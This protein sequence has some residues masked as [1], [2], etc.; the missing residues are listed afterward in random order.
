MWLVRPVRSVCHQL[1]LFL[2]AFLLCSSIVTARDNAHTAVRGLASTVFPSFDPAHGPPAGTPS[3]DVF[4][5]SQAYPSVYDSTASFPW[6]TIDFRLHPHSYMRAVLDYCLEGNLAVDFRLQAN[7]TRKW[8]HAP[9]LHDD[10]D[11]EK[12]GSGREFRHGLTRERRSRPG[13][14]HPLQT[15]ETQNWA[16]G[17]YN[18]RGGQALYK[19]WRVAAAYPDPT[20]VVFPENSVACKLLFSDADATSKVPFL[21]G[22]KEWIANIYAVPRPQAGAKRIDRMVRLLQFDIAVKEPR[23]A[24]TTGWIF[25]TFIYDASAPYNS[26]DPARQVFERL[27]PVGLSWGDDSKVTDEMRIDGAFINTGLAGSYLNESLVE[28]TGFNYDNGAFVRHYGLGGRLNGPVDNPA[29]SCISC[30]GRAATIA[31]PV[32]DPR[33]GTPMPI[34]PGSGVNLPSQ[35]PEERFPEMFRQI[36]GG[37]HVERTPDGQE[38]ITTD[39]ALQISMGIRNFFE[40]RR[41]SKSAARSRRAITPQAAAKIKAS[42]L[43]IADRGD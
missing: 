32:T 30:H 6:E 20:Q 3:T 37:S 18:D 28:R 26:T 39:Y 33:A 22:S 5:L 15:E 14:I 29:S 38:Y 35:F 10:A 36:G 24:G 34:G 12:I 16:V 13:E 21:A 31:L 41:A 1:P 27:V 2:S 8:Y 4:E 19:V 11:V 42:S 9:W 17:F 25:G 7:T 43:P 40:V 23:L